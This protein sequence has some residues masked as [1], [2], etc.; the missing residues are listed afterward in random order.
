MRGP[1]WLRRLALFLALM[2]L[3]AGLLLSLRA[4]PDLL[5]DLRPG[6]VAVMMLA[7]LP[8]T[9]LAGVLEFRLAV[10]LVGHEVGFRSAL[11][12]TIL[13][14]A[15]NQLPLPGATVV[16]I[17]AVRAAGASLGRGSASILLAAALW[18]GV[19]FLYAG[20]WISLL[21]PSAIGPAVAVVGGGA[22]VTSLFIGWRAFGRKDVLLH[23]LLVKL[24]LVLLEA[25]RLQAAFLA[26]GVAAGFP[27]ASA[28]AVSGVLGAAAVIVPG[29]LGIRELAAAGVAPLVGLTASAAFLATV[30]MRVA[31]LAVIMILA[32]GLATLRRRTG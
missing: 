32:A 27:Q 14:S 15:A 11:E 13:G 10:R 4:E 9:V 8:A 1:A 17:V 18:I 16:R 6:P 30:L 12:T 5:D 26:L 31:E 23:L 25:L 3:I 2:V 22:L 29:G 28:L 21:N 24:V 19:A 7:L 20:F